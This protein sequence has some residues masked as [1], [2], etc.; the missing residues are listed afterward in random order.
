MGA[1]VLRWAVNYFHTPPPRR[2]IMIGPPNRGSSMADWADRM[3]GPGFP[4]LFGR[5]ARD[6][7]TGELGLTGRAGCLPMETEVA[8]IAGGTGRVAG[9]N[10]IIGRDND[11]VVAVDETLLEG[12]KSFTR[13]PIPHGPLVFSPETAALCDAFLRT[14]SFGNREMEP[15]QLD[16]SPRPLAA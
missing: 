13:L 9:F 6:L 4:L 3:I 8:I 2:V 15:P 14:G 12:M 11:R 10:P 16:G 1:L 7:R 5:S